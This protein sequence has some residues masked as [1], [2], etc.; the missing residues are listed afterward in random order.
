MCIQSGNY[1]RVFS[2][3]EQ[4]IIIIKGRTTEVKLIKDNYTKVLVSRKEDIMI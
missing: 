2:D 3:P 4:K 1:N